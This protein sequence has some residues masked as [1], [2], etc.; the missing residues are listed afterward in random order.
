MS[1]YESKDIRVLDEV[2]HIQLNPG[3]YVGTTENPVHLIEEALDNALDEALAGFS[4]IIAVNLDIEN[5]RYAVLDNGRG[6]PIEDDVPIVISSKLFSGAKF[7]DQKNAYKI[8]SG[9]HGV[10]LVAVN[11]LSEEYII[12]IY[13]GKKHA[14]YVFH[15]AKLKTKVVDSFS[16]DAPFSTKI[17]FKPSRKI[18]EKLIP[19][20]DRIR[21]RLTVA[22]S[23]LPGHFVLNIG[24]QKSEVFKLNKL[25]FFKQFCNGDE[26][27][28]VIEIKSSKDPEFFEVLFSYATTGTMAQKVV[29][30]VN[31]LPVE[32]GGTHVLIFCELLKDYFVAKAKKMEFKFQPQDSLSGLRLFLNLDLI[33]P[34]FAGQTKDK[35][36]NRKTDFE[37][38]AKDL[39]A[40]IED[41]F[42]KDPEYLETL[43]TNFENYRK[44]LDSK[45]LTSSPE[46]KRSTTKF[47][48]LRDCTS[49]HG[50]LFIVEGD[51]AA[52][53]LFQCRDPKSVAVLPLKGKIPN[54][55]NATDILKN[56]EIGELIGALGTGVAPHFDMERLRYDKIICATD[57]DPDGGHIASLLTMVFAILVP[58]IIKQGKYFIARTPLFAINEGK[59]FIPLWNDKDVK[60]AMSKKK[61]VSR[62]KGLGELSPHQLKTCLIDKQ[63]RQLIPIHFTSNLEKIEKIFSDANEK[64]KLLED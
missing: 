36:T 16:G 34:K 30:C 8:S 5:F 22:A 7:Q 28:K 6:I 49:N 12:E 20:I 13:R 2:T 24:D 60:E 40:K 25:Q 52:G 41:Y 46:G 27:E 51:S 56:K 19:D 45:K 59:T 39:K 54:I 15:N 37:N 11:A 62:F 14:R 10:G 38:F 23:Q 31:L 53:C 26:T 61:H 57:A 29:S 48:K 44:K 17:E 33:E 35:L 21:S 3:M 32:S 43:L 9:L 58:E 42:E 4:N 55:S 63:T 50:E 1:N 47:T 64:R 18:F